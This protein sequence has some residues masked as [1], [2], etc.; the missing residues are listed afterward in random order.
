[1]RESRR[2]LPVVRAETAERPLFHQISPLGSS[3]RHSVRYRNDDSFE[4]DSDL[5]SQHKTRIPEIDEIEL[6]FLFCLIVALLDV[7]SRQ[8]A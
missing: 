7:S 6:Q 8:A 1:M 2:S 5:A 3:V 4:E